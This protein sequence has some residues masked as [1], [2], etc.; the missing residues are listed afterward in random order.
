MEA[1][2]TK[3]MIKDKQLMTLIGSGSPVNLLSDTLYQ[4]LGE[5][6]QIS[7]Q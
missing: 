1:L 2:F 4:Q 5:P 6:S 7:V 3:I